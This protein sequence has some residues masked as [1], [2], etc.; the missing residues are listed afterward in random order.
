MIDELKAEDFFMSDRRHPNAWRVLTAALVTLAFSVVTVASASA[1]PT[2]FPDVPK[3]Q[4]FYTQI[5]WLANEG[6]TTGYADGTFRPKESVSREA[7][8][9]FLYRMAE[10]PKVTLPKTSPF[11]DV[12]ETDQFYTQIVWAYQA[13]IT[14]GW[15]DGT[16][17]PRDNIARDAIAAFLYRFEGKPAF[18]VTESSPFSDVRPST[19]F[20][21][22]IVWLYTAG[23]TTGFANGSFQPFRSTSREAIA[24]FLYRLDRRFPNNPPLGI[25][26]TFTVKGAGFGHGVGMSQ[27]GA[28]GMALDGYTESRILEHYFTGT[29][30]KTVP[31][32][33]QI[34]VEIFGSY[35]DN[36]NSVDVVVRSPGD[37]AIDDGQ[38]EMRFF[39][40]SESK[41]HTTFK[42]YN[43][44]DVRVR[45]DGNSVT[46]TREPDR[47]T[48]A[49]SARTATATNRIELV[50]ESTTEFQP[51]STE[52]PY[53]ELLNGEGGRNLTHGQYRHGKLIISVPST[54]T[55]RIIISN[56]LD[57]NTEYLYGIAE[58]PSSWGIKGPDA[59]EAQAITARGYALNAVKSFSP[60]CNCNIYDDT[61]DQNFSGW[62]KEGEGTN[63][64]WG[65]LWVKAVDATNSSDGKK[66]K[67]L[68]HGSAIAKTYY[69]SSSGGQ[70]E[71]SEDIWASQPGYLTSVDDHWSLESINPNR[72]WTRTLTQAQ[73]KGIFG[74]SNIVSIK[75]TKRTAGGSDAAATQVTATSFTGKT[76]TISGSERIRS[77]IVD[78]K[79]PWIWSFTPHW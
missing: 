79:S 7:F 56:E 32:D 10:D 25:P 14:T 35:D 17:R 45:R 43:N 54:T 51:D 78:G 33:E 27:Y 76:S 16:F 18:T 55:P 70:T 72:A 63:A 48:Q 57:L 66:G 58:M 26:E 67:V 31:V 30:V 75:V 24:A 77:D 39:N 1:A 41:A 3:S 52:D 68:M 4:Q 71:R 61:R 19:Q 53:V 2:S 60:T 73:A 64:K 5:T 69:F 37:D 46:V 49:G 42:G 65:K 15:S 8:A 59:L 6:I 47:A 12:N 23:I 13:G 28:Y 74:I 11:K 20:F 34:K 21:K 36:H 40:T 62:R 44:E 22:E 29:E 9:A 50:W 38:W